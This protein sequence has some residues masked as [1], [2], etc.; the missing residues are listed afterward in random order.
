MSAFLVFS[1]RTSPFFGTP[2]EIITGTWCHLNCTEPCTD[3]K[4][5]LR[6][7][8]THKLITH[9]FIEYSQPPAKYQLPITS[10]STV[11]FQVDECINRIYF[12]SRTWL[13]DHIP[14][15]CGIL[16]QKMKLGPVAISGLAGKILNLCRCSIYVHIVCIY[17]D[18]DIDIVIECYRYRYTS[19]YTYLYIYTETKFFW[20]AHGL[21]WIVQCYVF[22]AASSQVLG[23]T[24]VDDLPPGTHI[25][26]ST[27]PGKARGSAQG[28]K[29]FTTTTTTMTTTTTTTAT[30][31]TITTTTT[32][33]TTARCL[34]RVSEGT[35]RSLGCLFCHHLH[36]KLGGLLAFRRRHKAI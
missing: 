28:K 6:G 15:F 13:V 23:F 18:I 2:T 36:M 12:P 29:S 21:L 24:H 17:I 31:I 19:M 20:T 3:F 4:R 7:W 33:T 22:V 10:A 1:A 14:L 30:T 11:I 5:G 16:Q 27:D 25:D 34:S 32:T 9:M 26:I 8:L 35:L